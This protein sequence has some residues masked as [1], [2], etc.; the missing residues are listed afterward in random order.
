MT[1][2]FNVGVI[3]LG[4]QAWDNILPT[5][6]MMKAV[7][8]QCVSDICQTALKNA[9]RNYG[10]V[11]YINYR[12]MLDKEKIDFIIVASHPNVHRDVL[13]D[14]LPMGIPTFVEKPPTL[15]TEE[16]NELI[17]LNKRFKTKTAVG[18]NFIFAEPMK[19]LN[20]ILQ[21]P[22]F[23][24]IQFLE[25]SHFGNKPDEPMWGLNDLSWSF[26][27]SQ[28][29]HP[30]GVIFGFGHKSE[31]EP[32][33]SAYSTAMGVGY[34]ASLEMINSY[35]G[36]SFTAELLS[37]ST[38]PF[39]QWSLRMI[40]TKGVIIDI[41]SLWE[42]EVYSNKNESSL[43]KNKKW[44]RETWKPSPISGGFKRN[45]YYYQFE[46]F[47][48]NIKGNTDSIFSIERCKGIY[49]VMEAMQTEIEKN[50]QVERTIK[51]AV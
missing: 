13:L 36:K 28:A 30:L 27:L 32:Y 33:V 37:I 45:G 35:S 10:A 18:L 22:D 46:D 25:V 50:N 20:E 5:L 49:D 39:F 24:E 12:D 38:S 29:I 6:A 7:N 43:I 2:T 9:S 19:T 16:L 17:S 4:E 26:L 8:I 48:S 47:I 14:T 40:S 11:P 23:G 21:D 31:K 15:H 44:W 42:M 34:K 3:G 41:N 51:L 1:E